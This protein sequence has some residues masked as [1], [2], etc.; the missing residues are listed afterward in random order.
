MPLTLSDRACT[1]SPLPLCTSEEARRLGIRLYAARWMRVRKG[2][3]V[4]REA[5]EKLPGRKRYAVRVHA[6]VRKFPDAVL[7][8]ESAGVIHGIPQFD[9]PKDIHVFDPTRTASWRHGDVSVHT[10]RDPR[11]VETVGGVLVTSLPDTVC[12]LVRVMPAA[13]ALAITDAVISPVQGGKL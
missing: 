7:C 2:I 12:D 11:A 5:F 9:E 6:F 13:H 3:Y 8:F 10:S 1:V 4:D